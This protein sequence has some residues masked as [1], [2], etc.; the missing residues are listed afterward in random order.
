[1]LFE[2]ISIKLIITVSIKIL[3][4]LELPII[5]NSA[6]YIY[7]INMFFFL[8]I[9]FKSNIHYYLYS[10]SFAVLPLIRIILNFSGLSVI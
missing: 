10:L 5:Y 9:N 1:M 6:A 2:M 4:S 8:T 7:F 3:R